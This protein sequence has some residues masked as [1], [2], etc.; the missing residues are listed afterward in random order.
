MRYNSKQKTAGENR[1]RM[2]LNL[3]GNQLNLVKKLKETGK[4]VIVVYH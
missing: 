2:E 1:A 4:N 3:A